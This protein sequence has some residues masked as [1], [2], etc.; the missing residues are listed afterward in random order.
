MAKIT[1]ID[2]IG[3]VVSA[4]ETGLEFWKDFLG[5]DLAHIKDIPEQDARIAFL[6]LAG[7]EIELLE[8]LSDTSGLAKFLEKRGPGMHHIC[9]EVDDIEGMMMHLKE[10]NIQLLSDKP[11]VGAGGKKMVFIH[12]KSAQGVLV[13]LYQQ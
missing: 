8:P 6:P 13:E 10:K 1:R 5:L 9:L 2:H 11:Q 7:A 3:I 12:P 4:T